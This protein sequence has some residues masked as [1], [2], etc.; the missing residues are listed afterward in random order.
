[1]RIHDHIAVPVI[2]SDLR[3]IVHIPCTNDPSD[4]PR[5]LIVDKI[6]LPYLAPTSTLAIEGANYTG[7]LIQIPYLEN[8]AS[9]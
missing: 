2:V 8:A 1:M 7:V 9:M 6:L 5:L 3:K 4:C